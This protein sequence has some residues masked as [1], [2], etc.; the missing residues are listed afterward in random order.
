MTVRIIVLIVVLVRGL[1]LLFMSVKIVQQY[2]QGVLFRSLI[3][4]HRRAPGW[5]PA[6]R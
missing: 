5:G 3:S 4:A 6:R 1:L 2:A